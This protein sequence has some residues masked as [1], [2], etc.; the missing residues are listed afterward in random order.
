MVQ[1]E[2]SS[3]DEYIV[4]KNIK[5]LTFGLA[6]YIFSKRMNEKNRYRNIN[7]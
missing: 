3:L 4:K 5:Q 1:N 7:F 6:M 2:V